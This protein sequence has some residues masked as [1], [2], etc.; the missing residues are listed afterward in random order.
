MHGNLAAL[1]NNENFD[2]REFPRLV[3]LISGT[4]SCLMCIETILH[5]MQSITRHL[6]PLVQQFRY[7][8]RQCSE[9]NLWAIGRLFWRNVDGCAQVG[10]GRELTHSGIIIAH[11]P[12]N[13]DTD[14][15]I[16]GNIQ[17]C[18]PMLNSRWNINSW[19]FSHRSRSVSI[20]LSHQDNSS[21]RH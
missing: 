1:V 3:Y 20:L 6:R 9:Q 18:T 10:F 17:R 14:L 15:S 5:F 13:N 21:D 12:S 2:L 7:F 4:I 11:V 16:S 8:P 19:I